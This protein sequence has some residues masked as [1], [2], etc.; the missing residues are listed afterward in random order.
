MN[1]PMVLFISIFLTIY[2]LINYY[3]GWQG[4]HALKY[5]FSSRWAWFWAVGVGLLALSYPVGRWLSH[6]VPHNFGKLIIYVGSYWMAA[7][8]YLLLIFLICDLLRVV[9]RSL[10]FLPL[11]LRGKFPWLI[12]LVIGLVTVILIYGTWNAHHPV[13][14]NYEV[15]LKQK[16]SS[17]EE[18]HIVVVS[19]I[20]LG[21]IVGINRLRYMTD[22][23]NAL[24]PDLILLAGDIVDE[25]VDLAAEREMPEVFHTLHPRFGTY[26][27]MGNH[28]YISGQA[29]T[30]AGFLNQNGIKVLRDKALQIDNAFYVVGR[31]EGSQHGFAA[32]PRLKIDELMKNIDVTHLPVILVA[33]EPTDLDE[34]DQA[35]VDL[36]FSGHTHLGQ[37]FPNNYITRAIYENDWGYLRKNNL[38]VIVSSGYGTWGPPIRIGNRPEIVDV[39]V[40]FQK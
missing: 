3:I 20:H 9:N 28:E 30:T 35:G 1:W 2:T 39:I 33:H 22:T 7:M 26:A 34:V 29:E 17:L 36:Q 13:V 14:R 25:G 16:S 15:S 24:N 21:W 10:D 31:D 18:L 6:Y 4:W 12:F 11:S 40:H 27:V 32:Q 37:L 5:L 19:D 38:Q 8:Y 23:I